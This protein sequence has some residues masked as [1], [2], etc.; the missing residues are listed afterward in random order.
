MPRQA[1]LNDD[2]PLRANRPFGSTVWCIGCV[3]VSFSLLPLGMLSSR[4]SHLPIALYAA[5]VFL[6]NVRSE[7]LGK[8]IFL[9]LLRSFCNH[10]SN[11]AH[12]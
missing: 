6:T 4:I 5:Q 7:H 12:R 2:I 9:T 8:L 1:R 11:E 10:L 3:S